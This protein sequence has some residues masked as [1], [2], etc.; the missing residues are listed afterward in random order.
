MFSS[1]ISIVNFADFKDWE[2]LN[3]KLADNLKESFAKK[4]RT[5]DI[6]YRRCL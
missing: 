5:Y 4:V 6:I 2:T 1:P 3:F